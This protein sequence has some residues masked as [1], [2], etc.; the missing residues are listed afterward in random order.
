MSFYSQSAQYLQYLKK[1]FVYFRIKAYIAT[2]LY[3]H[4]Y[5][6]EEN[7]INETED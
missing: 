6:Y 5:T 3:K 1:T 7:Y 2:E 4:I